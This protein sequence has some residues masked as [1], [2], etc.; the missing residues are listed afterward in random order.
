MHRQNA[1]YREPYFNKNA[2][3]V[4]ILMIAIILGTV[5]LGFAIQATQ[6]V[7][8]QKVRDHALAM[9]RLDKGCTPSN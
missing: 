9:K 1:V 5:K 2:L 4:T 6:A 7:E 3:V 8:D